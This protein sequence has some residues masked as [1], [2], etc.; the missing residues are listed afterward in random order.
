MVNGGAAAARRRSR[1]ATRGPGN[2]KAEAL[3]RF[4]A[5][6]AFREIPEATRASRPY[7]PSPVTRSATAEYRRA[8]R[9]IFGAR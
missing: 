7:N 4:K 3:R 5:G 6:G 2:S 1:S 9:N 8:S